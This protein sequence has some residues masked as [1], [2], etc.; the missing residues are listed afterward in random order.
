MDFAVD[1]KR[2]P[3]VV[4]D[5]D[6]ELPV[7]TSYFAEDGEEDGD[8]D[9]EG[10]KMRLEGSDDDKPML[11]LLHGLS[12]GSYEIYLRLVGISFISTPSR[13]SNYFWQNKSSQTK[14]SHL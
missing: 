8:G 14:D 12:G 11:V 10:A 6:E 9:G 5:W 2:W 3:G 7:R 1:V 4:G 13:T